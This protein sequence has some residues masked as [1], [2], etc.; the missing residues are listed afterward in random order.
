MSKKVLTYHCIKNYY[1]FW[2]SGLL[3]KATINVVLEEYI[4][5]IKRENNRLLY[6]QLSEIEND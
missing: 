4:P 5:I 1:D 2:D 3:E 6:L